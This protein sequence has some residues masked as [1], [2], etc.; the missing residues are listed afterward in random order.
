MH[1]KRTSKSE[2]DFR[3]M[4]KLMVIFNL[5]GM[6]QVRPFQSRASSILVPDCLDHNPCTEIEKKSWKKHQVFHYV[7]QYKEN[8]TMDIHW[9]V[10][11]VSDKGLSMTETSNSAY[12][13]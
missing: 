11:V 10:L 9:K 2:G 12:I 1:R 6:A 7:K 3:V 5:Q 13:T 4:V 8:W